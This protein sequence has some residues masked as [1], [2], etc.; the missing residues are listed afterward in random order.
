MPIAHCHY[1]PSEGIEIDAQRVLNRWKQLA[2]CNSEEMTLITSA[3]SQ[4]AG[5]Q[6]KVVC[7]L[8]LPDCWEKT[9]SE[10]LQTALSHAVSKELGFSTQHVIVMRGILSSGFV[11]ENGH[12]VNW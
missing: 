4:Q 12:I 1:M 11:V 7:Y 6:Y 3:I 2:H 5:K 9:Q 8:Y 10:K